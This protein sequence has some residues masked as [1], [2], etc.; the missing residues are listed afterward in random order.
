MSTAYYVPFIYCGQEQVNSVANQVA[1]GLMSSLIINE[2]CI[3]RQ[4]EHN[5]THGQ[6]APQNS[7]SLPSTRY[8][9]TIY[10]HFG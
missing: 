6:G 9:P 10:V 2:V 8:G 4:E 5:N 3:V 7:T 1:G